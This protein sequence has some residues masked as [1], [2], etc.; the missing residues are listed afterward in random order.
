MAAASLSPMHFTH[1]TSGHLPHSAVVANTLQVYSIKVEEINE[2]LELKWPLHVYGVVAARDTV[3]RN[4]NLIFLRQ[5]YNCQTLTQKVLCLI[6]SSEEIL[7]V[8]HHSFF[9]GLLTIL[10]GKC[11]NLFCI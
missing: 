11:R 5:R 7:A 4:R 10:P 9:L 3:D 8:Y 2:A 1:C 6:I